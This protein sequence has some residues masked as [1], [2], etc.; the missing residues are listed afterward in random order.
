MS[1]IKRFDPPLFIGEEGV[2]PQNLEIAFKQLQEV[3]NNIL[4]GYREIRYV[5][6]SNPEEGMIVVADGASWNPG[7]GAGTYEYKGGAWAKL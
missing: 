3:I 4:D 7:S 5:A 6:P 2:T 1:R